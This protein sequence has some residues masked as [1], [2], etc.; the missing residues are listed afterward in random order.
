M[1][2]L[3]EC[4][5][6]AVRPSSDWARDLPEAAFGPMCSPVATAPSELQCVVERGRE[7]RFEVTRR[8]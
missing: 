2:A 8:F 6:V 3:I 7:V 5:L 1:N 4:D